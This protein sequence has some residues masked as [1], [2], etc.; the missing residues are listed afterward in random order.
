LDVL[1][2]DVSKDTLCCTFTLCCTLLNA[3]TRR[4]LWQREVKNTPAGCKQLLPHTPAAVPWVLE[5]SGRSSQAVVR[6]ARA[7]GRDVG[8][9]QPKKAPLFLAPLFLKS[10]Q[11]RAK[12]D[13]L[14]AAGLALYGLSCDLNPEPLKNAMQEELDQLMSARRGLSQSWCQL[15]ARQRELPRAATTL[16]PALWVLQ[17]RQADPRR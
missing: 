6:A 8:L 10:V 9:A 11:S 13:K 3:A 17:D 4:Q 16:E 5:P 7:A 2:L 12:T 14:D 1:G 15:Q